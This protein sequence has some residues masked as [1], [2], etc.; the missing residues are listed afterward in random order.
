MSTDP[1]AGTPSTT[2][3]E[4]IDTHFPGQQF[5]VGSVVTFLDRHRRTVFA[6]VT[7]LRRLEAIVA[8]GETGRWRVRYAGLRLIKA[9]PTGGATTPSSPDRAPRTRPFCPHRG[10]VVPPPSCSHP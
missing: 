4:P 9:G 2:M 3:F 7:E 6:T 1:A 10:P 5:P 8:G